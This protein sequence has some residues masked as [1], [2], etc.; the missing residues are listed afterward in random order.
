LTSKQIHAQR[1][2]QGRDGKWDIW[3]DGCP[4]GESPGDVE[5]RLDRVIEDIRNK[6]H[7]DVMG[8]DGPG[9]NTKSDVLVVAHGHILRALAMRWAG[10][11]LHDGPVFLLEAGGVGTLRYAPIERGTK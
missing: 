10:K 6:W 2:E 5:K 11:A 7:K 4:G 1:K 3:R 9:D 8:G